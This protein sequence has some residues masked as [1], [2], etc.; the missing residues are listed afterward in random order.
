MS[1]KNAA[2]A[3]ATTAHIVYSAATGQGPSPAQQLATNQAE[4]RIEW[5]AR[6]DSATRAAN[7]QP[8]SEVRKR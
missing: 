1:W 2:S 8:S 3:A 5:S 6:R 7:T 4:Q